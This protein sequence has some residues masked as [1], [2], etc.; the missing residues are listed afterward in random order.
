MSALWY[1]REWESS[2]NTVNASGVFPQA[3]FSA[4]SSVVAEDLSALSLHFAFSPP[5][6]SFAL[7][8]RDGYQ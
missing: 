6:T 7:S 4:R 1:G 3:P 5:L 2:S 8:K